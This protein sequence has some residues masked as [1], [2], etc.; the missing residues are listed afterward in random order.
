VALNLKLVIEQIVLL[1]ETFPNARLIINLTLTP[2]LV[3]AGFSLIYITF[4]PFFQNSVKDIN[5]DL[6]SHDAILD[7]LTKKTIHHVAV[8]VDFSAADASALRHAL[9]EIEKGN[10]ITLLHINESAGALVLG[11]DIMDKESESDKQALD[12]YAQRL[13]LLGYEV[14]TILGYGTPVKE[15]TKMVE[16]CKAEMLVM[17]THGHKGWRDTIFGTTVNKVRHG[18]KVP[19]VIVSGDK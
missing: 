18:V 13:K 2:L 6:H 5:F 16:S 11:G 12:K 15:I 10:K 14:E 17:A 4:K 19:V 3:F 9:T 8:A 7:N 1:H